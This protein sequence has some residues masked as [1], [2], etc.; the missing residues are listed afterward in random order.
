MGGLGGEWQQPGSRG[1]GSGGGSDGGAED[2]GGGGGRA[3]GVESSGGGGGGVM[4]M[5]GD[6]EV[7]VVLAVQGTGLSDFSVT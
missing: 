3:G 4:E 5:A 7:E 6:V 2:G 1:D